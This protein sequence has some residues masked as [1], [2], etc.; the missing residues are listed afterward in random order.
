MSRT[1]GLVSAERASPVEAKPLWPERRRQ[2][3]PRGREGEA[4]IVPLPCPVLSRS[5]YT[6]AKC[7]GSHRRERKW[8]RSPALLLAPESLIEFAELGEHVFAESRSDALVDA[9]RDPGFAPF[10]P[11]HF[12]AIWGRPGLRG[13]PRLG[14]PR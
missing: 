7:A 4:S 9:E 6:N 13:S 10:H 3:E 12:F 2:T 8:N 1:E 14:G 5:R 11:D